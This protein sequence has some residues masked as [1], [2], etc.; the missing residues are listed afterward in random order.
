MHFEGPEL[1]EVQGFNVLISLE[2]ILMVKSSVNKPLQGLECHGLPRP[3]D[4][5]TQI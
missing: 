4:R 5:R 3:I 2:K 1:F